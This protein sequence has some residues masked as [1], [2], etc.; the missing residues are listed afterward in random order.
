MY[1]CVASKLRRYTALRLS[2]P[3]TG[4]LLG[5]RAKAIPRRCYGS[6]EACPLWADYVEK[7]FLGDERYFLGPLMRFARGDVRGHIVSHKNSHRPSY[8][9]EGALQR[10]KRLRIDF[11]E[12]LGAVRFSTCSR[13]RQRARRTPGQLRRAE[14][15]RQTTPLK[16]VKFASR[17]TV[18]SAGGPVAPSPLLVRMHLN[19]RPDGAGGMRAQ[20]QRLPETSSRKN[21]RRVASLAVERIFSG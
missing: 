6:V 18:V 1:F 17:L 2:C 15:Y 11:C 19:V 5:H 13:R 20:R 12:I 9:R 16:G 4:S 14:R 3:A 7:P 8:R 21:F 10:S